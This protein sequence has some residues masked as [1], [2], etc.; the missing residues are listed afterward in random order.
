MVFV[1]RV[2]Q[3][4]CEIL[5]RLCIVLMHCID[6]FFFSIKYLIIHKYVWK[7]QKMALFFTQ[8]VILA[9]G[10]LKNQWIFCLSLRFMYLPIAT[11]CVYPLWL[12]QNSDVCHRALNIYIFMCLTLEREGSLP[13]CT[14]SVLC[15]WLV[16]VNLIYIFSCKLKA[17]YYC[18][19]KT[20]TFHTFL[21]L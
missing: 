19:L 4:S 2:N 5:K 14:S 1:R 15:S 10:H 17:K 6:S 13:I 20:C 9:I 7:L 11:L 21:T 18:C 3:I 8:Y 16:F 12:T